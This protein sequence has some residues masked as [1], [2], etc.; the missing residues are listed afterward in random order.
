MNPGIWSLCPGVWF[1]A[2]GVYYVDAAAVY[3]SLGEEL[4]PEHLPTFFP[5]IVQLLREYG[6]QEATRIVIHDP[7]RN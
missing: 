7:A 4:T 5:L 6:C 2:R 1:D 3:R